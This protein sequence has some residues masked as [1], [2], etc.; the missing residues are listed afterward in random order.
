MKYFT[1]LTNIIY[2]IFNLN[3]QEITIVEQE[4]RYQYGEW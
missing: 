3:E 2:V 4:T 1:L